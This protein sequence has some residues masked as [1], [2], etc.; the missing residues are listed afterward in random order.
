[1]DE[2]QIHY[3]GE[4]SQIHKSAYNDISFHLYDILEKAK[5][6]GIK[7]KSL[8]TSTCSEKRV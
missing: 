4:I 1:M 3:I 7:N 5:T 2:S 8:V 6:T